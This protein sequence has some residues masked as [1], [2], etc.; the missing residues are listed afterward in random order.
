[1]LGV[2][3]RKELPNPR[4]RM[5]RIVVPATLLAKDPMWY[6][7]W[8]VVDY[9]ALAFILRKACLFYLIHQFHNAF[10]VGRM[11]AV[12]M[13]DEVAKTPFVIDGPAPGQHPSVVV[14]APESPIF[15]HIP[16]LL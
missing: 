5:Y 8:C 9:S 15:L 3:A 14:S 6:A 13:V 4:A 10:K 1:M 7:M 11:P 12:M 2:R 16:K